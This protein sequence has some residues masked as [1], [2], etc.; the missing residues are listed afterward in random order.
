VTNAHANSLIID[1]SG[2]PGWAGLYLGR[3]HH[4]GRH[5]LKQQCQAQLIACSRMVVIYY[6]IFLNSRNA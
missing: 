6:S 1:L 4:C 5:P 3:F 2:S